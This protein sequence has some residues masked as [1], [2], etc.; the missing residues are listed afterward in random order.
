MLY[1]KLFNSNSNSNS[2]LT[3][4]YN[5]FIYSLGL[6]INDN[7]NISHIDTVFCD[8]YLN[9]NI[10]DKVLIGI[11][12]I[13]N[14]PSFGP[15]KDKYGKFKTDRFYLQS[16]QDL[17]EFFDLN[18]E[19][20]LDAVKQNGNILKFIRNQSYEI[21]L[22]AVKSRGSA[23]KYVKIQNSVICLEAVKED[24]KM[25]EYVINQTAEICIA[26][27]KKNTNAKKYVKPEF[28]K[29][30]QEIIDKYD[31]NHI[32]E[33]KIQIYFDPSNICNKEIKFK[34]LTE[35]FKS[36][37]CRII[38]QIQDKRQLYN[39]DKMC[40]VIPE[41]QDIPPVLTWV[42]E[43]TTCNIYELFLIN[44]NLWK[45]NLIYNLLYIFTNHKLINL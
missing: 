9:V 18:P 15:I 2:N 42:L 30:V 1:Y 36:K 23:L 12:N 14:D 7:D 27:V 28:Y 44:D 21:C 26:A 11:C 17:E 24:P 6:N 43:R 38:N 41:Y 40:G 31:K 22:S 3:I 35:R 39:Q 34:S 32:I 4:N 16:I 13:S 19:I 10:D 33:F 37:N 25:L 29:Y 5:N 45:R 8:Q 20:R